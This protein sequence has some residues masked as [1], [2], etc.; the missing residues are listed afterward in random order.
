MFA[1]SWWQ[2]LITLVIGAF[3]YVYIRRAAPDVNWGAAE[4]GLKWMQAKKA[5]LHLDRVELSH[6]V[7]TWRPIFLAVPLKFSQNVEPLVAY[8]RQLEHANGFTIVAI[9]SWGSSTTSLWLWTAFARVAWHL[10][11]PKETAK[12]KVEMKVKPAR[13]HL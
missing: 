7:K 4:L 3:L 5:L 12:R 10:Q 2:A 1:I 6:H 11:C 8:S 13:P 9:S